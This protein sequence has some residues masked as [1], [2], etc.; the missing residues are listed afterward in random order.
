MIYR[1]LITTKKGV[2]SVD[3]NTE[4]Q[5]LGKA[6]NAFISAN[7]ISYDDII[8]IREITRYNKTMSDYTDRHV[9]TGALSSKRDKWVNHVTRPRKSAYFS[10]KVMTA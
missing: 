5:E 10:A 3:V 1:F 4:E 8:S 2:F 7:N 9:M 6:L